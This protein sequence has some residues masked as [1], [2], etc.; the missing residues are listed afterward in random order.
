[1]TIK[2][3]EERLGLPR[4]SIRYYEQEGLLTP[5]RGANGYRNYSE[6]DLRT[7]EKIKLLRQLHLDLET[8][9]A[10]QRGELTLDAALARQLAGL[11]E[12]RAALDRA[13]AV[14]RALR[15]AG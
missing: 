12:D 10:L 9:R 13:E 2:E 8:I 3:L 1:M 11:G 15:D 4:A 5:A 6:E 7:L 14:C